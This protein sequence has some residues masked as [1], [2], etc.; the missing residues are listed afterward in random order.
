M[1][2]TQQGFLVLVSVIILGIGFAFK[3]V[4]RGFKDEKR[5][6]Q[7]RRQLELERQTDKNSAEYEEEI[8]G[9]FDLASYPEY[10]AQKMQETVERIHMRV[11]NQITEEAVNSQW[12]G[13]T[14]EDMHHAIGIAIESFQ[15]EITE[16]VIREIV[17]STQNYI[18]DE[19]YK[20]LGEAS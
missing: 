1:D 10:R 14:P 11:I 9:R 2:T 18:Q 7:V 15:L 6:I 17:L 12:I 8:T 5:R 13:M 3:L 20:R 16:E 4:A 19:R